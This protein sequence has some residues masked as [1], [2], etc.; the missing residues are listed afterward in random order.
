[1]Q[2][3]DTSLVLFHGN[4]YINLSATP[5]FCHLDVLFSVTTMPDVNIGSRVLKDSLFIYLFFVLH[6]D[7][8]LHH[9][10]CSLSIHLS[11]PPYD[12]L[13][14]SCHFCLSS[15]ECSSVIPPS[16]TS[17]SMVI[18]FILNIF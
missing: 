4:F 3:D 1:M 6:F 9:K 11:S 10:L 17:R 2:M 12:F 7:H 5:A 14:R 8:P 13:F 18:Y 16:L 15:F